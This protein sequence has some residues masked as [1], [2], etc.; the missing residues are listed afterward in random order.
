MALALFPLVMMGMGVVHQVT[1]NGTLFVVFSVIGVVLPLG[2]LAFFTVATRKQIAVHRLGES[3][4]VYSVRLDEKGI[5]IWNDREHIDY[6]WEQV[7]RVYLVKG[8]AYL[9]LTKVKAFILPYEY[10]V[11]GTPDELVE[12]LK[13]GSGTA[14]VKDLRK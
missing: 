14:R 9:Y 1:G 10:V 6:G 4:L 12:V 2:Y 13:R 11:E 7:Y 3:R 8:Y 5:T